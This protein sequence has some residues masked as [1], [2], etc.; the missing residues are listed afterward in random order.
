MRKEI[1][2]TKWDLNKANKFADLRCGE[3]QDLYKRR[4]GFK[5]EDIVN[6]AL[7]EIGA[8]KLLKES[9]VSISEPDFAIY[10]KGEKSFDADLIDDNENKFHIKGQGIKSVVRYG[11]SWLMQRHDPIISNPRRKHF[12]VPCV[13]DVEKMTVYVYGIIPVLTMID[14]QCIGECAVPSFRRT[15]IAI[16]ND[17][18]ES[19]LTEN[20]RWGLLKR[21]G[22]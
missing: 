11:C 13:V 10:K 2:L 16:Y 14:R 12:I 22:G 7:A 5:R 4:G 9:G 1:K 17:Y 15:K 19:V 18:M 20:S 6:G 8:Y 3:N 21:V